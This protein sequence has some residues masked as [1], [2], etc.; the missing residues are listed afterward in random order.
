MRTTNASSS[1][2]EV[3]THYPT[4]QAAIN[5]AQPQDTIL[6]H[7]NTYHENIVINK[8]LQLIGE[9]KG[10]TIIEGTIE[11]GTIDIVATNNTL[12]KDFTVKNNGPASRNF[13]IRLYFSNN[14]RIENCNL[15]GAALYP[16]VWLECSHNNIIKNNDITNNGDYGVYLFASCNNTITGNIVASDNGILFSTHCEYNRIAGNSIMTNRST[17]FCFYIYTCSYNTIYQNS[18]F[19]AAAPVL[20]HN[21]INFWNNSFLEGNYWSD[22]SGDDVDGDG[23]GETPYVIDGSKQ[24]NY[25]L[26]NPYIAGDFNHD[27]MVN[28]TDAEIVRNAWM[29]TQGEL[30]YNPHADFDM[31]GIINITDATI[32]GLN[33]QKSISSKNSFLSRKP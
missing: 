18:F 25:P 10:T 17:A 33:W 9:S 24:D 14:C 31:D 15:I 32:I 6:V 28:M 19:Y 8:P 4:I 20:S 1:I 30:D 2:I 21:S 22:Y 3:P 27:G 16:G 26:M 12:V 23:V 7:S 13:P 29:T 11:W 5:A